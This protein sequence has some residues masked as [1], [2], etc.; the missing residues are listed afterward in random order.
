RNCL[1][2]RLRRPLVFHSPFPPSGR[3]Q[4]ARVPGTIPVGESAE[5]GKEGTEDWIYHRDKEN[6]SYGKFWNWDLIIIRC[7]RDRAPIP[8]HAQPD[9]VG[10]G[11]TRFLKRAA[12]RRAF[13][14][15]AA[16][17]LRKRDHEFIR[18]E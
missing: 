8:L 4:P 6:R 5:G 17:F 12:M 11:R 13:F 16:P 9:G 10:H 1:P 14:S 15:T 2:A 7:G 18:L 3:I